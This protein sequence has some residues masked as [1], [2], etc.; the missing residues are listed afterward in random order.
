MT[1]DPSKNEIK[2]EHLAT[3]GRKV[4]VVSDLHM[5]AG[6]KDNGN[7]DGTENFY[8]DQSFVRF[9]QHLQTSLQGKKGILVINGD[10]VDFLRICDVPK[11]TSSKND[12]T[13]WKEILQQAGIE[14]TETELCA[15]ISKKEKTYGL[16]THDYKSVWKLDMCI[17]GHKAFFTQL[18][19][20]VANDN[21][22]VILKGNHDLEWY[23]EK[24]QTYL[25]LSLQ[26]LQAN[27]D[28]NKNFP[29][30]NIRFIEDA[31]II[32]QRIYIEH[33]HRYEKITWP[34]GEPTIRNNSEL[35]LPFG[36]FINRYLINQFELSYPFLD[37][38]RPTP[39][40]L[41]TLLKE[42]FP[43][44]LRVIT[45]ELPYVLTMVPGRYIAFI[46]QYLLPLF[47]LILLPIASG[48]TAAVVIYRNGGFAEAFLSGKFIGSIV[49]C[50]AAYFGAYY[51]GKALLS[52]LMKKEPAF[53]EDARGILYNNN[54]IEAVLMGHT[55]DP[56]QN[57]LV[58]K[59]PAETD[60][61]KAGTPS[62][63]RKPENKWY[64]NTGTWIPVFET[65]SAN[66]RFDKTYT[67]IT[68]DCN[69]TPACERLQRWNDDAE[70]VD[71]M[72]LNDKM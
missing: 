43:K 62:E 38:V 8:A 40:I 10:F 22:L 23:W 42:N 60:C 67:F 30:E 1:T 36:S 12:F 53:S 72:I 45:V 18:A 20:W 48:I 56:E 51:L 64:F 26:R 16:E 24:V 66:V 70:R 28:E 13:H 55:H 31:L 54:N 69:Q 33:G 29:L 11:K 41:K 17:R 63:E 2:T 58:K 65:S 35:N 32:D 14:K 57:N 25:R 9:L 27:Q 4:F 19:Q 46:L 7:Y 5:A 52:F 15:S 59:E 71:A 6:L 21:Q 3:A 68:I 49:L 39:N 47:L 34:K 61:G 50:A 37:N 44:A